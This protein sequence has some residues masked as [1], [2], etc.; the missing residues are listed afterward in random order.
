[1]RF[2]LLIPIVM[3]LGMGC[4][5][6]E[7]A[8]TTG[9]VAYGADYP[10]Y[11]SDGYY[12]SYYNDGWY[13]WSHDHWVVSHW[14]PRSPVVVS[15]YGR[16]GYGH[17]PGTSGMHVRDHRSNGYHRGQ[18][19]GVQTRDHRSPG[20]RTHSPGRTRAAPPRTAPSRVKTRDHRR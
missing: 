18:R 8:Y 16:G 11:F 4:V 15:N 5:V 3:V 13:M 20:V 9:Y 10:V 6:R 17:A 2:S 14:H 7:P 1:M 19:A 12:W